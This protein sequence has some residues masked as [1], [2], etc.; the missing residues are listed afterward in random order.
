MYAVYGYFDLIFHTV[1]VVS[2]AIIKYRV[3][4]PAFLCVFCSYVTVTIY[5]YNRIYS[6]RFIL[7][8]CI[9]MIVR[10]WVMYV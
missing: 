5:Y 3:R 7:L 8:G 2:G 10:V 1:R 4:R 6:I 9:T